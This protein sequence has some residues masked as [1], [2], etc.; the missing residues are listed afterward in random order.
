MQQRRWFIALLTLLTITGCST[1]FSYRFADTYL[2]WQLAKYVDLSGQLEDEVSAS[3]DAL[4]QWHGQTQMPRYRDFLDRLIAEIEKPELSREDLYVYS[5]QVFDFWHSLRM[6]IEPL[7][8]AYLPR[9]SLEQQAMLIER[10]NERLEEKREENKEALADPEAQLDELYDAA[11][12]WLG[13]LTAE[14]R[15]LLKDAYNAAEQDDSAWI[16]YQQRWLTVFTETL[17]RPNAA[18][19]EAN[20]Q[21][22]MT[23]PEQL[24]S[25]ALTQ[26]REANRERTISLLVAL[27]QQLTPK[28]K[29]HLQR[30]L[31][32]YRD[33]VA[34]IAEDYVI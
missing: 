28:Q 34:A 4:H 17:L 1:S 30:K 3:I 7:A 16:A 25:D 19:F 14:Q 2:E 6:Q 13:A 32:D 24:Q 26:Q 23:S 11:E 15:A 20:V 10:L 22:L 27:H 8:Q 5:F 21:M 29:R 12:E 31:Q 33:T 9:L 18:D